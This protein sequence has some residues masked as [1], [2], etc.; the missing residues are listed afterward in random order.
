M[1]ISPN[2]SSGPVSRIWTRTPAAAPGAPDADSTHF[3]GTAAL[4]HALADTP[5][6]RA[7]QVERARRLI[8]TVAYPPTET[9]QRIASLLATN[10]AAP[11]ADL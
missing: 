3:D 2:H 4:N 5:D 1:H 11:P 9:I 6:V 10:F 8:G 7:D